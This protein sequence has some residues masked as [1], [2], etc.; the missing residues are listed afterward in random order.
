MSFISVICIRRA[1]AISSMPPGNP[2]LAHNTLPFL[3][4]FLSPSCSLPHTHLELHGFPPRSELPARSTTLPPLP[5]LSFFQQR[6]TFYA[7]FQEKSPPTNAHTEP[8]LLITAQGQSLSF[9]QLKGVTMLPALLSKYLFPE[10]V[11]EL[12]PRLVLM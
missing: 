1:L 3:P 12:L 7:I 6:T 4:P 10:M 2:E 9:T 5:H 11:P 8:R